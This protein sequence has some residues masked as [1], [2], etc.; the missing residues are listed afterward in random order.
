[1][2]C[3]KSAG[4]HG[5]TTMIKRELKSVEIAGLAEIHWTGYFRTR[6]ANFTYFA[7]N[8]Q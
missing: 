3:P 7:G 1:M 5:K 2:E 8:D 6:E 4:T